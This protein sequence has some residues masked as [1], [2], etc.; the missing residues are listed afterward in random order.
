MSIAT[1]RKLIVGSRSRFLASRRPPKSKSSHYLQSKADGTTGMKEAY[2]YVAEVE[3]DHDYGVLWSR[4][5]R[6]L[7]S[8]YTDAFIKAHHDRFGP[9]PN[10]KVMRVVNING[11]ELTKTFIKLHEQDLKERMI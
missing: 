6:E 10:I 7:V 3:W 8:E 1:Q 9:C 2:R 11:Y 5:L 4:Q